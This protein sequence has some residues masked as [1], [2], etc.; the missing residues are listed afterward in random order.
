MVTWAWIWSNPQQKKK[1]FIRTKKAE[2]WSHYSKKEAPPV[3]IALPSR[4]KPNHRTLKCNR[5]INLPNSKRNNLVWYQKVTPSR[6]NQIQQLKALDPDWDKKLWIKEV[7]DS[8]QTRNSALGQAWDL[9]LSLKETLSPFKNK[10]KWLIREDSL[11]LEWD[12]LNS[13]EL[14]CLYV[15]KVV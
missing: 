3:P 6:T 1:V 7:S 8:D 10:E 15:I 11:F 5:C 4:D 14:T 12:I 13:Q 2:F 9:L